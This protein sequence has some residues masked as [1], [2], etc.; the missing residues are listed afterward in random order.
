MRSALA[1]AL[2]AVLA[3][4]AA[5]QVRLDDSASPRNQVRAP[6]VLSEQG[7]PL[8]QS[9]EP[10]LAIVNFGRI[11]YRLATA[12]YQGRDARIYYAMPAFVAGLRSPAA[13]RIEWRGATRLAPGSLRPGER[14]L[15]W[16]GRIDGPWFEDAVD[17][18]ARLELSEI[19]ETWASNFGF[20]PHF[21]I[22]VIR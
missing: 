10:R 4:T 14:Q 18:V 5:A 3:G 13:L 1:L 16:T 6:V 21:E 22:E 11:A 2:S 7:L 20:Q 12:A 9:L 17:L 19:D 8:D 15:V